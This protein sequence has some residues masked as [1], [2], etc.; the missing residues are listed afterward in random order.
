MKKLMI[1]IVA[2]LV[3]VFTFQTIAEDS[4]L[5]NQT[6]NETFI[7]LIEIDLDK[8]YY[9]VGEKLSGK[10]ILHLSEYIYP[11]ENLNVKISSVFKSVEDSMN[12]EDILINTS[13]LYVKSEEKTTLG[14]SDTTKVLSFL[15]AGEQSIAVKIP[16][17]ANIENIA[18]DVSAPGDS[19]L[20]DVKMDVTN[21][22]EIDWYYLGN[23]IQWKENYT[24]PKTFLEPASDV[25]K[26]LDNNTYYCQ[27]INFP[28]SIDYEI[29]AQYKKLQTGGDIKAL[30]LSFS[31]PFY[32][33]VGEAE[34]DLP[35]QT[36]TNW[37]SCSIHTNYGLAG[38]NLVCIYSSTR[39][40][41]NELYSVQVD[42]GATNTAYR[43]SK[44]NEQYSCQAAVLSD[45]A[46]KI[47]GAKYTKTLNSTINFLQWQYVP[48]SILW[49]LRK[50]VGSSEPVDFPPICRELEC[51]IEFKFIANGT[52][53]ITLSNL[54]IDF[55]SSDGP[56]ETTSIYGL[57][58]IPSKVTHISSGNSSI[59]LNNTGYDLEI[60]LSL[61]N[62]T[63]SEA[64]NRAGIDSKL[65]VNF[66]DE[67]K[68]V[69]FKVLGEGESAGSE[70]LIQETEE[71]LDSLLLEENAG[72]I[73]EILN[74]KE[75]IT[76]AKTK[77]NDF[78]NQLLSGDSEELQNAIKEFRLTLP[79]KIINEGTL[80]DLVS[81]E[82]EDISSDI[83]PNSKRDETYFLQEKVQVKA[84][85]TSFVLS[86]FSEQEIRYVLVQKEIT[87]KSALK[88]ID[89]FEVI[90]KSVTSSA[91]NIDFQEAPSNIVKNDP[92]VKWFIASLS[93]GS[94]KELN[95]IVETDS[96]FT[97]DKVK[98]IITQTE[99]QE[100]IEKSEAVCGDGVCT[101]ILEDDITCPE[102]CKQSSPLFWT[103]VIIII[104]VLVIAGLF[105]F[106]KFKGSLSSL[107]SKTP[108]KNK[109]EIKSLITFIENSKNKKMS[110]VQIKKKLSDKGWSQKQ[111]DFAYKQLGNLSSEKQPNL[112]P[113]KK[114]IKIAL[115]KK[116]DKKIIA[117]K[118]IDQGWD[119][120][121]VKKELELK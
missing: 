83:V 89:I 47:K 59:D 90:D 95:Y 21:D 85:I 99:E 34:C 87:A 52:G 103:F 46:I 118:L 63:I 104:M 105:Y 16:Q 35:E 81:I 120:K 56:G 30:I 77:L 10:I 86:Y 11:N 108:F 25:K 6:T 58:K 15:E 68:E 115:E 82:P 40:Q 20:N 112:E 37:V 69:I 76:N 42:S 70:L 57:I 94:K 60:P 3:A 29:S 111:I 106:Y 12:F 113:M 27:I 101:S 48:N 28:H 78:K 19:T 24:I 55:D 54:D 114:Y 50:F 45:Y 26:I 53:Q 71:A 2:L 79:K 32:P 107:F 65:K 7:D 117:K 98:T 18:L 67:E 23:F 14:Q 97:V 110:E 102:D 49:A 66:L 4:N 9:S 22:G 62:L 64:F 121:I 44:D 1:I 75:T 61:F 41:G 38:E 80:I 116:V 17:Y 8:D 51:A 96:A 39:I 74:L 119:E 33:T 93:V 84:T 13:K 31:D 100:E 92:I 73:L 109:E 5:T 88:K 36:S 72:L 91:N 43:C